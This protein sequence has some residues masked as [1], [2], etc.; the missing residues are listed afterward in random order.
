MYPAKCS[1]IQQV[2]NVLSTMEGARVKLIW[3]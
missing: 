2:S 1:L 3:A